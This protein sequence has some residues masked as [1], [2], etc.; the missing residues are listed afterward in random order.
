MSTINYNNFEEVFSYEHLLEAAD[1]C[2]KNVGWKASVQN[3]MA[4]KEYNV[5][6][7]HNELLNGSFEVKH[8]YN[9]SLYERGKHREIQSVH[10][11]ERIVQ[12]CL[13]DYCLTPLLGKTLCYDNC[14]SQ[15]NKGIDFAIRR[16]IRHLQK[17]YRKYG[18]KGYV[19]LFDFSNYFGSIPH[20]KIMK[21]VEKYITDERIINL[22]WIFLNEF[23]SGLGLGSQVSQILS[24]FAA[25][26]VDHL[27]KDKKGFKKYLRYMDDGIVFS[28]N[29]KDLEELL[30]LIIKEA[31]KLDLKINMKKTRIEKV[32]RFTFLKKTF[33]LYEN[34]SITVKI[35]RD[36]HVRMRRKLKRFYNLYI[37]NKINEEQ[38]RCSYMTWRGFARKYNNFKMILD[39]DMRFLKLLYKIKIK[40]GGT[41]TRY[42]KVLNTEGQVV[43][44]LENILFVTWNSKSNMV[45]YCDYNSPYIMGILSYNNTTIWQLEGRPLFP[46]YLD[47]VTV[48][49]EEID[50]IE[51]EAL[52]KAL[53][54]RSEEESDE[55]IDDDP[56]SG[57]EIEFIKEYKIK[58]LDK[59]CNQVIEAGV[60][61]TLTD[62]ITRH[63]SLAK[64]DQ[65]NL[66]ERQAQINLGAEHV[67][68]H[69]DGELCTYYSAADMMKVITASIFHK[70]FHVTYFNSLR[71]YVNSLET[72]KEISA[73]EY[74]VEIPEEYQSQPLKDL[75]SQIEG[76]NNE[77]SE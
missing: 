8:R 56:P 40:E 51:Y 26:D 36:S 50:K 42:I 53:D 76:N 18:T 66:M 41:M 33:T 7:L 13:C 35:S 24:L 61:V 9:F 58:E 52:R 60:D 37:K 45:N 14:A 27:I 63:Y 59:T 74:G 20:D 10:I 46:S 31:E 23:D 38:I 6:V 11:R 4:E 2:R 16:V 73:I 57:E 68:Y 69:A 62:G 71:E 12:R 43:D 30:L 47:F 15:K 1:L 21:R 25:N 49:Y 72:I 65:I 75:Y 67:S 77:T 22:L 39:T 64:E 54:E 29:K 5:S 28:D 55:P 19:L 32:K 17:H 44:A 34:G 48:T 3:F 70:M